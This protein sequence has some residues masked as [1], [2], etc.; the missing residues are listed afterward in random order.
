MTK[1][2][3][4]EIAVGIIAVVFAT[5][6]IFSLFYRSWF[7]RFGSSLGSR[8]HVLLVGASNAGKTALF[9]RLRDGIVPMTCNSVEMNEAEISAGSSESS[10]VVRLLDIPGASSKRYMIPPLLKSA[11]AILF[12][13]DSSDSSSVISS[14]AELLHL[15]LSEISSSRYRVPVLVVCSKSDL[16]G[17]RPV[18]QLQNE[19]LDGMERLNSAKESEIQDLAETGPI[20]LKA[21]LGILR[22]EDTFTSISTR[23]GNLGRVPEFLSSL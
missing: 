16:P 8:T 22:H 10:G 6:F 3:F 5:V 17:A 7:S 19:M 21:D 12:V 2:G 13:V 23:T 15:V 9:F 18:N 14:S 4:L 1:A 11:K 20:R